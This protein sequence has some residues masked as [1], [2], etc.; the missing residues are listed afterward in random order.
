MAAKKT[1]PV[2]SVTPNIKT[3]PVS[4]AQQERT[5]NLVIGIASLTPIGRGVTTARE[6]AGI[7]GAGGKMVNALY[8]DSGGHVNVK[9]AAKTVGN[10][11]NSAKTLNSVANSHYRTWN[12]ETG[13]EDGVR[14]AGKSRDARVA[15]SKNPTGNKSK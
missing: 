15:K 2:T 6:V 8:K 10:P 12:P 13:M 14:S 11:P 9:P 4:K 7:K 5:R 3:T 1:V